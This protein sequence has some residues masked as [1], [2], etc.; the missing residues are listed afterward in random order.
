MS[1]RLLL[2]LCTLSA[3]SALALEPAYPACLRFVSEGQPPK[4]CRF[5]TVPVTRNNQLKSAETL[6]HEA[7]ERR[8]LEA[9]VDAA[10]A[11]IEAQKQALIDAGQA[12]ARKLLESVQK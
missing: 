12:S 1:A 11:E 9:R 10:R 7:R 6:A 8:E 3:Q 5:Q 4:Y 2:L